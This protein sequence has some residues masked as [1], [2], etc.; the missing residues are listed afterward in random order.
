[1][2]SAQV[3]DAE[4]FT[5]AAMLRGNA[6][7]T[8]LKLGNSISDAGAKSV[9]ALL[10][11]NAVIQ[12]LDLDYNPITSVGA[13]SIAKGLANNTALRML[14]MTNCPIG[15]DGIAA[16]AEALWKH[17]TFVHL[18][19]SISHLPHLLHHL[20]PISTPTMFPRDQHHPSRL[21]V[22][23]LLCAA[24]MPGGRRCNWLLL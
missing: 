24:I 1:M 7:V 14:D 9:G 4:M 19:A 11:S 6:I 12:V 13:A 20:A 10:A 18:R 16:I 23:E 5:I 2:D 21:R 15:D 22:L 8:V 3:T 17:P